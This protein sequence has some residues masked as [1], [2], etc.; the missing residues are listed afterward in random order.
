M[1]IPD[2][3][4]MKDRRYMMIPVE[5]VKVINAELATT[6]LVVEQEVDYA[7]AIADRTYLFKKG[8]VV[9]ERAAGEIDK[10]EIEK[11]YF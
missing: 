8:R 10:A 6:I 1:D 3:L 7:L 9:M 5:K 11:A 4:A 2:I